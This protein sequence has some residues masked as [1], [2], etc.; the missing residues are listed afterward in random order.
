MKYCPLCDQ[1]LPD[2]VIIRECG[3]EQ[4]QPKI[5]EGSNFQ[6]DF[7]TAFRVWD[8]ADMLFTE[9]YR[10]QKEVADNGRIMGDKVFDANPE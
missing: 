2:T 10:C 7:M 9:N 1:E 3:L 8:G 4:F 5:V 6:Q